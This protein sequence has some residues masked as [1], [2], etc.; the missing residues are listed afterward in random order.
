MNKMKWALLALGV[1]SIMGGCAGSS[2]KKDKA[3]NEPMETRDLKFESYTYDYIGEFTY[4][5]TIPAPGGRYLKFTAEGVLP[6]DIG[7]VD[8]QL[9]RDSLIKLAGISI[10]EDGKPQPQLPDSVELT[11]LNARDV[12][13]CSYS[14]STLAATLV[15]PR[16]VVWEATRE[17]YPCLAA[18]GNCVTAYVN[19]NLISGKIL[20]IKDIMKP[21]YE[22]K[23]L[24]LIR[25]EVKTM[26]VQLLGRL[27]DVEISDEFEIASNGINFSYDPYVI[28]PFSEGTV[29]VS[30]PMSELYDLLNDQGLYIMTGQLPAE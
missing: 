23:L 27:S 22:K 2:N 16:V 1:A 17:D 18:H 26:K 24:K 21:G 14:Y 10:S 28:A 12:E 20:N 11:E 5:D 29:K 7:D 3:E 6:Q 19:Y 8:V 9:L 13:A 15:T 25:N 30:I 4:A